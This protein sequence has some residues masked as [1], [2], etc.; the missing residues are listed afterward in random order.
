LIAR[1]AGALATNVENRPWRVGDRSFLAALHA[2]LL[3]LLA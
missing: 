2:Q 3:G 1:E